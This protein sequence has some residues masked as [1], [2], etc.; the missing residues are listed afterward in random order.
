MNNHESPYIAG[1]L[2]I[3]RIAFGLDDR[4][5]IPRSEVLR[6]ADKPARTRSRRAPAR[7][8]VSPTHRE[9]GL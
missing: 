2:A 3:T 8:G 7:T 4:R 1:I 5:D 6:S 9:R